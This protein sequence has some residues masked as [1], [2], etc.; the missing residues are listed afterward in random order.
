M[1]EA[2]QPPT[3]RKQCPGVPPSHSTIAPIFYVDFCEQSRFNSQHWGPEPP[4]GSGVIFLTPALTTERC[5]KARTT[6]TVV[7]I[8]SL[9]LICLFSLPHSALAQAR[10]PT[11]SPSKTFCAGKLPCVPTFHNNN[12]RDGVNPH[13]T[14]L[15][16]ATNFSNLAAK[17]VVTDGLIYTQPLY[18]HRL[19]GA[20]G[21]VGTCGGSINTVFVATENNTVYGINA[22][23][24]RKCWHI[25]LDPTEKPIPSS[26]IMGPEGTPCTEIVP[27]EGIS[28]TPVIDT[29]VTPPILYVLTRHQVGGGTSYR[30]LLH[31]IDTTTG[32]EVVP[33]ADIAPL[34]GQ[35]FDALVQRQRPGLA[36]YNPSAG[37][38]N[39]Y[40]AWGSQCD[41]NFSGNYNGWVSEFQL[42]YSNLGNGFASLGTF[43]TEPRTGKTKF[44]G[45]WMSGAAP[46]VDGNGNVY[47]AVGNGG[48]KAPSQQS[49]QWGE[50]VLK[51]LT[52]TSPTNGPQVTDYYTPNDYPELNYGKRMVCFGSG[53][54]CPAGQ[55][56][57]IDA[58]MDVGSG[59]VVLMPSASTSE[60]VALGK[61]GMLYVIPYSASSGSTMGGLDG[62]LGG[63]TGTQPA[64]PASTDCSTSSSLPSPGFIAQCFEAVAYDPDRGDSNGLRSTPA[65]W[66]AGG[67]NQF[68]YMA[69]LH[70]VLRAF[71]YN[72]TTFNTTAYTPDASHSSAFGYPGASISVSWDGSSSSSGVTWVL[73]TSGAGK[74]HYNKGKP[75]YVPSKPALLYAF[76][77]TPNSQG[78]LMYLWDS[79]LLAH[80]DTAMPGAVK[81]VMPTIADGHIFIAGGVPNYFGIGTK[82][83]AAGTKAKC[84]GQLTILH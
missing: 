19:V 80:S 10:K 54:P 41:S 71:S 34:L 37:M 9:L 8:L 84:A 47:L 30:Q 46:S 51:L 22:E 57:S 83:C 21:K 18:I 39:V 36:L 78:Q 16:P 3:T 53:P 40:V 42:N 29:T 12:N 4:H 13:E 48:V 5:M 28:G 35:D 6:S 44:G 58:D 14:V 33:A 68:L 60:L 76:Q 32:L 66:S 74:I 59:G 7:A 77:A 25:L 26:A 72:G 73:D 2:I 70:D 50:S 62:P 79:S 69:G 55:L 24:G 64:D 20:N 38:A 45:I 17:T 31:A 49:G 56:L 23:N 63:Y 43:T 65:F 1:A 11:L 75:T 67:Q 82:G 52:G 61:Q 81:F 27:E 15:S